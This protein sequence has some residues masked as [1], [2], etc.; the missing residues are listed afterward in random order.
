MGDQVQINAMSNVKFDVPKTAADF[1]YTGPAAQE[2]PAEAALLPV[3]KDAPDF[4][5]PT[6]NGDKLS[7]SNV[8]KG[9]KAV[10]VNFWF[11]S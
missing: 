1:K 9:K 3:G 6:L 5:L 4:N 10:L 8:C 11:Y 7:L 2:D